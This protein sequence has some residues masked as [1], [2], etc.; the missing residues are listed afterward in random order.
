ML[1]LITMTDK[2]FNNILFKRR[3]SLKKEIEFIDGILN[4]ESSQEFETS[5]CSFIGR[6]QNSIADELRLTINGDKVCLHS[7]NESLSSKHLSNLS[8]KVRYYGGGVAVPIDV[9]FK[10]KDKDTTWKNY[11]L[12]VIEKL[13]GEA[14]T[15]DIAYT[16]I[17][18]NKDLS[19]IQARQTAADILPELV[20]EGKLDIKKGESKKEG[21]LYTLKFSINKK[22]DFESVYKVYNS[23][24]SLGSNSVKCEIKSTDDWKLSHK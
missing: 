7:H 15:S 1:K 2:E 8:T 17:Q 3:E 23:L 22:T 5:L 16:I 6:N 10:G 19:F 11:L 13:G 20:K 4:L 21:N 18:A 24:P 14:K 9:H 12:D